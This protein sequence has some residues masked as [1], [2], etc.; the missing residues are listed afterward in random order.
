MPTSKNIIQ[1]MT[2]EVNTPSMEQAFHLKDSMSGIVHGKMAPQMEQI[3]HSISKE[4]D[5]KIVRFDRLEIDISIPKSSFSENIFST[6]IIT[7]IEQA[8]KKKVARKK[9]TQNEFETLSI[10]A[11]KEA[12][13]F[14]FLAHGNLPWWSDS[15]E[16][17]S[18]E[19]LTNCL[20]EK[21]FIQNLKNSISEIKA[22]GRFILQTDN[23]LLIKTY[24]SF[25]DKSKSA[26]LAAFKIP[27]LFRET[28]YKNI[29]WKLLFTT[30]SIR[31]SE[32]KIQKM[33]AETAQSQPKKKVVELLNFG[34]SLLKES[35]KSTPSLVLENVPKNFEEDTQLSTVF[36]NA[37][38]ILLHP[39]L[40]RF[41]ESQ[42]LLEN[43]QFLEK[44][45]E[46]VL[47]L[48]HYLA[49]GK[50]KPYEYE[51]GFAKLLSGYPIDEPVNRFIHLSPKQK[52]ACDELLMAVMKH[53]SALKSS[54]IELLRNEYLQREGKATYKE[55]SMLLQ[56]ERK[57]QDILLDQLPWPMGVLKLPWLANVIYVEW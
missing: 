54:S 42:Q 14:Y 18:K 5:D 19:W 11:K 1:K 56:F 12:A 15:K 57:P 30:S 2:I 20:N 47:H 6:E 7:K 32:K 31:E 51:V 10:S 44:K 3:F 24:F 26:K 41:F 39:F 38:L 4:F 48:F 40:K 17:F 9:S 16:N 29:F 8:L 46:E 49:T 45:N 50:T 43:G 23:K 34:S 33:L 21:N 28:K 53:W 55:D 25:L 13:Y 27:S 37:G 36:E 35:E 52:H 22:L